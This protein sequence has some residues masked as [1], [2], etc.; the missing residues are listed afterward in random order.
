MALVAR[1]AAGGRH[2]PARAHP[3]FLLEALEG[4]VERTGFHAERVVGQAANV[5]DDGV[6]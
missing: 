2:V 4:G 6:G 5:L 3:P 1:T